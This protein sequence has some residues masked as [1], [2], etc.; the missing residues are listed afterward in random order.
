MRRAK[1]VFPVGMKRYPHL[2]QRRT[3]PMIAR[4]SGLLGGA[5]SVR[6]GSSEP[7]PHSPAEQIYYLKRP[8]SP[9]V[10][11]EVA[12]I[13][14]SQHRLPYPLIFGGLRRNSKRFRG[15]SPTSASSTRIRGTMLKQTW[16]TEHAYREHCDWLDHAYAACLQGGACA[17]M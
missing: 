14:E 6:F 4:S 8:C 10:W 11:H 2:P 15:E 17:I 3:A 7:T 5:V 12:K 13:L 16:R 9:R 1:D